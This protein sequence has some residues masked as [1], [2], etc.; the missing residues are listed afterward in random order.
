MKVALLFAACLALAVAMPI[1]DLKGYANCPSAHDLIE[2]HEGVRD[3]VYVDTTGHKTIG[4]GYNL[5]QSGAR[6]AIANIGAD[7]DS[8]YSGK[9]CLTS[10]QVEKLFSSSL[11]NAVQ[12]ARNVVSGYS[13]LCSCV[14]NVMV[15]MAFNLGQSG[16]GSFNTFLSYI[17]NHNWSAAASDVKGTLWCRQVGNRCTQDA[18]IIASGC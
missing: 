2:Q 14:Q 7:F 16:L 1:T 9:T 6:T 12:E 13:G 8:I 17:N 15:D 4:V 11:N 18:S 3:C 10:S 5:D